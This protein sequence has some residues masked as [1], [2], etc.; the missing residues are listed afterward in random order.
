MKIGGIRIASIISSSRCTSRKVQVLLP[1]KTDK[2]VHVAPDEGG[3]EYGY[4][5]KM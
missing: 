4:S 1:L 3:E 5:V 2:L